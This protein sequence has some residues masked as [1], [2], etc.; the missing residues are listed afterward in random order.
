MFQNESSRLTM[1]DIVRGLY[2][3]RQKKRKI[4]KDG[5]E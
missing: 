5:N 4:L 1:H 2:F 3:F